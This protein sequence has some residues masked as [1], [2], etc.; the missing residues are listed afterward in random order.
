MS[1]DRR[2]AIQTFLAT[3][4]H[5]CRHWLREPNSVLGACKR[6]APQIVANVARWPIVSRDDYCGEFVAI[7][8]HI[9]SGRPKADRTAATPEISI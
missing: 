9:V 7:K 4:C 3:T 2:E 5:N 8:T 6:H 1:M